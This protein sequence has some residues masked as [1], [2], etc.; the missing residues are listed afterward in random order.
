MK[1]YTER[2]VLRR[3]RDADADSLFA[4]TCDARMGKAVGW[5]PHRGVEESRA[6]IAGL[7]SLP[8]HY[9]VCLRKDGRLLGAVGL[10]TVGQTEMADRCHEGVIDCWMGVPFWGNGYASEAVS[11][12]VRH[13]FEEL[14]MECL[15]CSAEDGNARAVRV[16]EKCGFVFHHT[17]KVQCLP[18]VHGT[19]T[20]RVNCLTRR[21]WLDGVLAAPMTAEMLWNA[22]CSAADIDP[23][24][25]YEAWAFG[26]AP[27]ALAA[28]VCEEKKAGTASVYDLYT[29]DESEALPRVGDYSIILNA[30]SHAVCLIE[31][32]ALRVLPFEEVPASHARK[33]GEGDGSLA[34]W[35]EVHQAFFS[36]ELEEYGLSFSHDLRVLCEEFALRYLPGKGELHRPNAEPI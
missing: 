15:W 31:T 28:L 22:F 6:L 10:Q 35:R 2:L 20:V 4:Y 18:Q 11:A 7:L 16:Q 33:E 5:Q 29:L 26:D 14:K 8:E 19:R 34:Y 27:D 24:T 9:A 1:L 3:W 36:K 12:L 17:D 21:R 32:T 30:Q 23:V 25:P 13:A